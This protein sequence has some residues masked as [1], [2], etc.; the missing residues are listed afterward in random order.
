MGTRSIIRFKEKYDDGISTIATIYQQYDGYLSCV[1]AKLANWL[2][3]KKMLNGIP[4]DISR[5]DFTYANGPRCLVAQFIKEFKTEVGYLYV[6]PEDCDNQD[7]NYDVIFDYEKCNFPPV[8]GKPVDECVEIIVSNFDHP[9]FFRGTI[10]Q[11]IEYIK[12]R[13]NEEK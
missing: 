10:D 6:Y 5:K 11:L 13:E 2:K 7:Y 4:G 1:G 12:L 3:N 9:P 8:W